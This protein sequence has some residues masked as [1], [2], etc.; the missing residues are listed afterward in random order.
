MAADPLVRPEYGPSL[1]AWLQ[2]RFGVRRRTT[3]ALAIVVLAI[4]GVIVALKAGSGDTSYLHSSAPVFNLRYATGALQRATPPPGWLLLLQSKRGAT[5]VQ[6][7]AVRTFTLPPHHGIVSG[8]LPVYAD[9]YERGLARRFTGF[10]PVD[11]GKAR[12]NGAPG[13]QVTYTARLPG[14]RAL[15]GRDV[16]VV[17][18]DTPGQRAAL[19]LRV[20]Q[21]HAAGANTGEDVGNVGAAKKP[22]RSFRFG[23]STAG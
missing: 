14:G 21:T 19:V 17:Q 5:F 4:G 11:E 22:F 20:L 3:G 1:P 8:F 6:S 10:T 12:V 18:N 15:F 16:I 23:T 7:F 13:Y 9:T 2:A